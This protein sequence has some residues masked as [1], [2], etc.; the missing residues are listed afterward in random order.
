MISVIKEKY[1]TQDYGKYIPGGRGWALANTLGLWE[2]PEIDGRKPWRAQS[3]AK[4]RVAKKRL[5]QVG[6]A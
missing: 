3:I 6:R 1:R 5:D 4:G 2:G